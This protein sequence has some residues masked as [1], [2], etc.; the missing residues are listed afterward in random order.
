MNSFRSPRR[1]RKA[2]L[3]LAALLS[4][5]AANAVA[6]EVPAPPRPDVVQQNLN[7]EGNAGIVQPAA[8]S[9]A[10][11]ADASLGEANERVK[12]MSSEADQL[13]DRLVDG[14]LSNEADKTTVHEMEGSSLRIMQLENKLAEAKLVAEYWE[15]VS[16]KD[17]RADEKIKALEA[18]KA[19]MLAELTRLREQATKTA[20]ERRKVMSDPDPVVAEITGA[21]GSIKAKILIPYMGEIIARPGD[22]LPNGQKVIGISV[23]GV[24]VQRVDGTPALLGFGTTVPSTR[25]VPFAGAGATV[26]VSQ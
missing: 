11:P 6:Q 2:V 17:H 7:P 18:E 24:K 9:I 20:N 14:A 15:T 19:D 12:A 5:V 26:S 13:L 8:P 16:G 3:V 1:T 10:I 22:M 23:T 4:S 25:P 21:A